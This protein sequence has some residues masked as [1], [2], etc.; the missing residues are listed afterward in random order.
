MDTVLSFYQN[1]SVSTRY[2]VTDHRFTVT[3]LFEKRKKNKNH[4]CQEVFA[5]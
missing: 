3:H 2:A 5:A 1:K 4:I